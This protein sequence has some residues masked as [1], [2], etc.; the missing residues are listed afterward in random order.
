MTVPP[1]TRR[2]VRLGGLPKPK[3]AAQ[4]ERGCD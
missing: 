1:A 4:S 3:A 2:G